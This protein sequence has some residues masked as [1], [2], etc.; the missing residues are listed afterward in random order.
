MSITCH[1]RSTSSWRRS[2][3]ECST[4]RSICWRKSLPFLY[5]GDMVADGQVGPN[6]VGY[7]E[8]PWKYSAGTPNILGVIASAQALRFAVDLVGVA[9]PPTYFRADIAIPAT[10]SRDHDDRD[11]RSH[12]PA[13][14]IRAMR[15]LSGIPGITIYGPLDRAPPL[16][17]GRVQRRRPQSLRARRTAQRRRGRITGRLPLRDPGPPR[18][19]PRSRGQLPVELLPVQLDRGRRPGRRCAAPDRHRE[20]AAAPGVIGLPG[21]GRRHPAAL[22]DRPRR[23]APGGPDS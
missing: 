8:L 5:G 16:V 12:A 11:W 9:G 14:R 10:C 20:G 2:G 3:W 15:P 1:S 6:H 19:R 21:S 13:H 4:P 17:A 18:A 7:N 23:A 22:H